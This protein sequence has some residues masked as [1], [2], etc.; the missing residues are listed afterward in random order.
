MD[1]IAGLLENLRNMAPS[2]P[3]ASGGG[4]QLPRGAGAGVAGVIGLGVAAY[5]AA[6]SLFDVQGGHRAVIFNRFGGIDR[7][8]V[9]NEGTHV[10]IPWFQ[11]PIIFDIRTRP[12]VFTS[13]TGSKDLQMVDITIRVLTQ[14]RQSA[15]AEIYCHLGLDKDQ[16]MRVLPSVVPEVLKAVVANYNAAQLI[17]Q[18]EQIS[19]QVKN[20]LKEEMDKFNIELSDVSLTN[21]SFGSEYSAAVERK[22]I[23]Q[24][25]AEKAKYVVLKA[26]Q[27]KTSRIIQAKAEARAVKEI[28][29]AMQGNPGYLELKRI[30]R[31]KQ[32]A[33]VIAKSAN[34]VYLNSDNLL[35]NFAAEAM[36]TNKELTQGT[37]QVEEVTTPTQIDYRVT[38]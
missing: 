32:V 30:D 2:M 19:M 24:Q 36:A 5:T 1:K 33:Q 25:D 20:H 18:R 3:A 11:E 22:Q 10:A 6:N 35:F 12:N 4:R 14:P 28:S 23:A 7:E 8:R 27:T 29:A 13:K 31:A 38:E 9:Y 21:I 34:R 17:T 16:D 37:T 26:K 15:L